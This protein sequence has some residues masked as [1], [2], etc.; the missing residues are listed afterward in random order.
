[1]KYVFV[2]VIL[3]ATLA[4]SGCVDDDGDEE[5]LGQHIAE[6]LKQE[7][8]VMYKGYVEVAEYFNTTNRTELHESFEKLNLSMDYTVWS[9]PPKE[10]WQ[11][12]P[13][14]VMMADAYQ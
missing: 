7:S 10:Y 2:A 4:L 6:T 8:E 3:I 1:M 12:G 11:C 9:S 13:C 14:N 5:S